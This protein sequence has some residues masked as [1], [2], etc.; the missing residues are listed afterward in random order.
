MIAMQPRP[1]FSTAVTL[2]TMLT[3]NLTSV[4]VIHFHQPIKL[5][6]LIFKL[7]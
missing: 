5:G 2:D 1:V 7:I 4:F 3:T 6:T